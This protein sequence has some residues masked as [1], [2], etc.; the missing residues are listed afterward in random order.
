MAVDVEEMIVLCQLYIIH[1]HYFTESLL[2]I[3]KK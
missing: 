2:Q 3:Y 1:L